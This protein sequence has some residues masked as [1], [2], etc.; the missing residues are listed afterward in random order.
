MKKLTFILCTMLIINALFVE[1]TV[2]QHDELIR[3]RIEFVKDR[4]NFA[5]W[6]S[7]IGKI[8]S[9]VSIS[10]QILPQLSTLRKVWKEDSYSVE[11]IQKVTYTK[12]RK[13]WQLEA[14]QYDVTMV[15]GPSFDAAKEFLL[16]RYV[17]TQREPPLI[18][19]PGRQFGLEIGNVCFVTTEDG[20]ET[21]SSIDFIRHNVLFMMRSEGNFQK[22]LRTIAVTLDT[23]L[24]KKT[25]VGSY[26]QLPDLPAIKTFSMGKPKIKLGEESLL[27]LEINNP[28]QRELRYFWTM[29]GGG[30]E[31]NLLENFV[32]YGAEAGKQQITVTV[33]NDIGLYYSKSVEIEVIQP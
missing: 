18:K 1:K 15:V 22:N 13:W 26:E 7:E 4:T 10:E 29:T 12:I 23:L 19:P 8:I 9:G 33:V 25:P 20:G 32:Y 31:K 28:Q 11:E 14:N 17:E 21:F 5:N 2:G 3:E 16:L 27:T 24:L 6:G 30:I